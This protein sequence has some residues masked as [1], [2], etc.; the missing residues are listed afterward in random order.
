MVQIHGAF[1]K[2]VPLMFCKLER[3]PFR[4]LD[5]A[6]VPTSC[7]GVY[8]KWD[9]RYLIRTTDIIEDGTCS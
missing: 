8:V 9:T 2:S 3:Q 5:A 1:K 6:I 4:L 7:S